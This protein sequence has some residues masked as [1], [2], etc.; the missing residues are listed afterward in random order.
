MTDGRP[1]AY[2]DVAEAYART[3]DDGEA[4]R[5]PVFER[6]LGDLA[7]QQVLAVACGQGRDA[8]LLADLGAHVVGTDI[9]AQMLERARTLEEASPRG[10]RYLQGDAATLEAFANAGFDGVACH[11]ALMDMPE[12]DPVIRSVA[13]VLRPAGWFVFSIVHPC[14]APHVDNVPDYLSES[15]YEKRIA[16][17]ALPQHAY[18]RPLSSYVDA[19]AEQR[20]S[21]DRMVEQRHETDPTGAVPGLLYLRCTKAAG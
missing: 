5:D 9:S 7:G 3:F 13:R 10:I 19:L 1:A 2:D 6:L 14:Y 8:R 12:L 11:M 18:H 16:L 4:L 15:R 20:L 17:E 21:I